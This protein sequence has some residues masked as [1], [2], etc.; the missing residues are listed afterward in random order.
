MSYA[1]VSGE[2]AIRNHGTSVVPYVDA[3]IAA[4]DKYYTECDLYEILLYVQRLIEN[5]KIPIGS[6]GQF[7]KGKF[8]EINT[9][10]T[11]GSIIA[12]FIGKYKSKLFRFKLDCL[13]LATGTISFKISNYRPLGFITVHFDGNDRPVSLKAVHFL[14]DPLFQDPQLASLWI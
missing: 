1:T 7:M 6:N 3:L 8:Q 13:C 4:L 11:S 5:Q 2:V 9:G 10:S 12:S 14:T